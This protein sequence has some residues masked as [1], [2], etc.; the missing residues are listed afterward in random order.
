MDR[1]D[2]AAHLRETD[3]HASEPPVARDLSKRRAAGPLVL[4]ALGTAASS[5]D[6]WLLMNVLFPRLQ[7]LWAPAVTVQAVVA[8]AGYALVALIALRF[9]HRASPVALSCCSAVLIVCGAL[10]WW[11]GMVGASAVVA[12]LGVCAAHFGCAW[13]RIAVGTSLCAVGSK[14]GIVAAAMAGELMGAAVRCV[15]PEGLPFGTV[16]AAVTVIEL[17]MLAVGYAGGAPFL[18]GVR[19]ARGDSSP[20]D[21]DTTNPD[22]FIGPSHRLF[23]LIAFFELIHGISLAERPDSVLAANVAVVAVLAVGA[24]VLYARRG[25]LPGE[26]WL[27]YAAALLMLAGFV[28]R[29]LTPAEAVLSS[30]CSFAGAAFSWV[31]IWT[32]FASVGIANPAGALWALGAGYT[33]QALGLEAGSVLGRVA[34]GVP[35]PVGAAT[36]IAASLVVVAFIGYL[37]VGMRGFS[38]SE[39]FAGIVPVAA[40]RTAVDPDAKIARGCQV[41]AARCGLSERELEVANLLARGRSGPQIQ[42]ELSISRNTAKTHVRHIYR[43]LDVHSQQ[44]LIDLVAA[45]RG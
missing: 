7:E 34:S 13:P 27:L 6:V 23:V 25:S 19:A 10:V 15:V 9:P 32:V 26:D 22:S 1:P 41:L 8:A 42:D 45:Q 29:P 24:A 44:E 5:V 11:R 31:L 33:M 4:A 18:R 28:L 43:K 36:G 35:G 39:A 12:T 37:L 21:L 30:A 2:V 16:L 3:A 38:F 14:R 17:G 20:V 40:L